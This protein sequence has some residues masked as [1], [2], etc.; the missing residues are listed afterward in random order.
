MPCASNGPLQQVN[1]QIQ[2]ERDQ[3]E[4]EKVQKKEAAKAELASVIPILDIASLRANPGTIP[5]LQ[6]QLDWHRQNDI[7][8]PQKSALKRKGAL[9]DALIDAVVFHNGGIL[10]TPAAPEN[11]KET[12]CIDDEDDMEEDEF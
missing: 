10:E 12:V 4:P 2:K 5:E 9:L 1:K 3:R 6:L 8:I 7:K 11:E